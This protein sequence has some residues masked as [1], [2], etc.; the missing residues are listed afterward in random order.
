MPPGNSAAPENL[1]P[2]DTLVRQIESDFKDQYSK[3]PSHMDNVW[4]ELQSLE[5]MDGTPDRF[6]S[7]MRTINKFMQDTGVL[8]NLQIDENPN[9]PKNPFKI[10]PL[11]PASLDSPSNP[12]SVGDADQQRQDESEANPSEGYSPSPGESGGYSG[13]SQAG[14]SGSNAGGGYN[15]GADDSGSGGASYDPNYNGTAGF[16]GYDGTLDPNDAAQS[17]ILDAIKMDV[18]K[19]MWKQINGGASGGDEGCAASV[20][21]VLDQSG[22]A[23]VHEMECHHLESALEG[24]GWSKT[25]KPQPGDVVIGYGGMSVAHTGIVGPNG[26]VF[27]NHSSTGTFQQDSLSYFKGWNQ[28]VFLHKDSS[29]SAASAHTPAAHTPATSAAAPTHTPVVASAHK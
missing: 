16:E 24:Q 3:D 17:A 25:T 21:A 13:G 11:N 28:V 8:P 20:S 19:A 10:D 23:D 26:S 4:K 12:A 9:D 5:Q 27:D 14:D 18:G 6:Q 29:T 7:D 22:A 2:H 1:S 15:G